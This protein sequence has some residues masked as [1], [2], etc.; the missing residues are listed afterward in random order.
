MTRV[1][2]IDRPV[3]R[4]TVVVRTLPKPTPPVA[5]HARPR[6]LDD[7]SGPIEKRRLRMRLLLDDFADRTVRTEG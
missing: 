6:D 4:R 7:F 3:P 1:T 2:R 5:S